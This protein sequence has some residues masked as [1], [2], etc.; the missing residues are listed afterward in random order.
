MFRVVSPPIIRSTNNFIYNICYRSTV[1]ATCRYPGGVETYAN[2]SQLLHVNESS[3]NGWLLPDA[4]DTV[5]C[6]RDDDG[7]TTR[8]M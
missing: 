1:V 4:V 5:I 7:E 3:N 8:N 6:A 2:Q